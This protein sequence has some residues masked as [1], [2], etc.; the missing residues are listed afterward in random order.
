MA[1]QLEALATILQ[2]TQLQFL[3]PHDGSQP[4]LIPFKCY[5]TPF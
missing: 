2:K 3:A 5:L 1:Q 4:S